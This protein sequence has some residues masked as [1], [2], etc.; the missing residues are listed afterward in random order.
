MFLWPVFSLCLKWMSLKRFA[1]KPIFE[2]Q[3]FTFLWKADKGLL[4]PE[5]V[6]SL[7][8]LVEPHL[9]SASV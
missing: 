9:F 3:P 2:E 8:N 1:G 5:L 4:G 6:V 7:S